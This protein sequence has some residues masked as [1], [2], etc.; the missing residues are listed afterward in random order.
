MCYGT[1]GS[2]WDRVVFFSGCWLRVGFGVILTPLCSNTLWSMR[3]MLQRALASGAQH[4]THSQCTGDGGLVPTV[5]NTE[6][7]DSVP[8]PPLAQ[9]DKHGRR[10]CRKAL[11]AESSKFCAKLP[12][13]GCFGRLEGP[14]CPDFVEAKPAARNPS[15]DQ[16]SQEAPNSAD[17]KAGQGAR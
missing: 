13:E 17:C 10:K 14:Y 2:F 7:W 11:S 4:T 3:P 1:T 9:R 12:D 8:S 5:A 6:P 15:S 16:W